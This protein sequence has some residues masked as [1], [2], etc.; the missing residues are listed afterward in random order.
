MKKFYQIFGSTLINKLALLFF[1]NILINSA[2]A[3][4]KT[5]AN[6]SIGGDWNVG[7]N[8][9]PAGVPGAG[10]DVVF[11]PI[12]SSLSITNVQTVSL[13]SFTF[14]PLVTSTLFLSGST[15]TKT[16]TITGH[17]TVTGASQNNTVNASLQISSL[18]NIVQA[19]TSV[20]NLNEG[21]AISG[22]TTTNLNFVA[23]TTLNY[24]RN[25][26]SIPNATYNAASTI[27]V[28][29][30]T[31]TTITSSAGTVGNITW[32]CRDQTVANTFFSGI[33]IINGQ[34]NILN[35]GQ[36]SM[37]FS[38][39]P[40]VTGAFI[41]GSAGV[42]APSGH[43]YNLNGGFTMLPGALLAG[44]AGTFNIGSATA[45][46][47]NLD[48]QA[49]SAITATS[50]NTFVMN[51]TGAQ[52]ATINSNNN[53]NI[54]LTRGASS[55]T[56]LIGSNILLTNLTTTSGTG[57][58]ITSAGQTITVLGAAQIGTSFS[59]T[60]GRMSGD[61]NLVI[62]NS[63]N[64]SIAG[65]GA[66]I[67][68]GGSA[69]G[70]TG[71]VTVHSG[72]ITINGAAAQT[73]GSEFP[74][75]LTVGTVT[76]SNTAGVTVDKTV[77]F[78]NYTLSSG[79]LTINASNIMTVSG[80]TT[81]SPFTAGVIVNNG[82]FVQVAPGTI[83]FNSGAT[84]TGSG[85]FTITSG[86]TLTTA[87]VAGINATGATGSVQTT[88]RN[89]NASANYT[90]NGST[91]N[92]G[93]GMP[94]VVSGV[95]NFSGFGPTLGAS[96]QF[97]S[98]VNVNT[99]LTIT[100]PTTMTIGSTGIFT[101]SSNNINGT[102]SFV[103][104]SGAR[105]IIQTFSTADSL[106]PS[107]GATT[108]M[109]RL[110]G[111]TISSGTIVNYNGSSTGIQTGL[112][113]PATI[114]HLI[115]SSFGSLV[116]NA[117]LTVSGLLFSSSGRV[118]TT[119]T[120]L[121]TVNVSSGNS[122]YR[123]VANTAGGFVD[124]P[125]A[126]QFPAS[127]TGG[128]TFL[129]PLGKTTPS[130]AYEGF[131]LINPITGAG[132]TY[133][134]MMEAFNATPTG[135]T[136]GTGLSGTIG[137]FYWQA[138]PS[139]AGSLTSLDNIRVTH[140]NITSTLRLGQSSTLGGAY[141]SLGGSFLATDGSGAMLMSGIPL[142]SM[143]GGSFFST[144]TGTTTGV[145]TGGTYSVGPTG[146]FFSITAALTAMAEDS[147]LSGPVI[148]ELQPTYSSTVE[149]YPLRFTGAVPTTAANTVTIRPAAAV[150]SVINFNPT[151]I[152]NVTAFPYPVMYPIFDFNGG[153]NFIIDGRPGGNGSNQFITVNNLGNGSALRLIN[154]AQDNKFRY[155]N[156]L[157][158]N[159]STAG[160]TIF[161]SNTNVGAGANNGNS[162]NR[163]DFCDINNQGIN[164]NGIR[165]LGSTAPADNK[166]DTITNCKIYDFYRQADLLTG[167]ITNVGISIQGGNTNWSIGTTV[168]NG[169]KFYQ[170]VNRIPL[171]PTSTSVISSGFTAINI[172]NS[173]G[174]GFNIYGNRIGGN[175]PGITG[176]VMNIGSPT[177]NNLTNNFVYAIRIDN[178]ANPTNPTTLL[179][180]S[181]QGNVISDINVTASNNSGNTFYFLGML[182]QTGWINIG[183]EIGNTIGSTTSA[184]NI[185]LRFR[186]TG[187]STAL[188]TGIVAGNGTGFS[189]HVRNNT[190]A[191]FTT[192]GD[193]SNTTAVSFTGIQFNSTAI[194]QAS[195]CNN[196][197]V[198]S[199]LANSIEHLS[200]SNMPSTQTGISF[201]ASGIT[202]L[203]PAL[204]PVECS[205]NIVQNMT[206]SAPL[207]L[208]ANTTYGINI[209]TVAATNAAFVSNGN[210]IRNLAT[211]STNP[212]LYAANSA[213]LGMIMTGIQGTN[214][215]TIAD[216]KI[217]NLRSTA[218]SPRPL[219]VMG[220]FYNSFPASSLVLERNFIHSLFTNNSNSNASQVGLLVSTSA[221]SSTFRNNMIR[222]GIQPDG[223]ANTASTILYG[224]LKNNTNPLNFYNNSVYIGGSGVASATFP[225]AAFY[226]IAN[227]GF[228]N[229]QNNIFMNARSNASGSARHYAVRYNTTN[230][231]FNSNFNNLVATGT[232]GAI[233]SN[234]LADFNDL[235]EWRCTTQQDANSVGG[236]PQFINPTGDTAALDLHIHAT[237]PSPVEATGTA[238]ASVTQ[239]Y[240]NQSRSGLTP[241]DIGADAGNFVAIDQTPPSITYDLLSNNSCLTTRTV[242]SFAAVTD[243]SGINTTAGTKPR[244]YFKKSTDAN[245]YAGNTSADNGWKFVEAT[246]ATSPFNFDVTYGIINGGS[247]AVNDIIQY[248]VVAQD[249]ATTPNVGINCG[250]FTTA[251]TSVALAAAAF[252]L[253]G[254]I[255]SYTITPA[256][257]LSGVKTIGVGQNFTTITGTGG[258][259]DSINRLGLA[260]DITAN[261][262]DASVTELGTIA[263]N[264]I[265]GGC[266]TF[267]VTI[268]PN[269]TATLTGNLSSNALIRLN[270]ADNVTIDGSNSGGSD[271]S[272]TISNTSTFGSGILLSSL[273]IGSG[274]SYNTIKNC[275]ISTGVAATTTYGIVISGQ[276]MGTIGADN[277]F[278]TIQN[279]IISNA[280][281]GIYANGTV[282]ASAGGLD[283][284]KILNNRIFHNS[285]FTGSTMGLQLGNA[286]NSLVSQD[287]IDLQSASTGMIGMSLE[288]GFV[289]S[290]LDRNYV[291]KCLTTTASSF[292]A[293]GINVGTGNINSNL[294]LSNNII[295]NVNGNVNTNS[296]TSTS[297]GIGLGLIG[298]SNSVTG[299]VTLL[300]NSVSMTGS[301]GTFSSSITHALYLSTSA[302]NINLRNNIFSNT[303][304]ATNP[305]QKNFAVY[306]AGT[307]AAFNIMN[308][309]NYFVFN[310]GNAASAIPGFT[311]PPNAPPSNLPDR[312]DSA[313]F[314][315]GFGQNANSVFGNPLF[316]SASDLRPSFGIQ[317]LAGG[318]AGTGVTIDYLGVTRGSPP[319]MGA[320]ENAVDVAGPTM[321]YSLLGDA[322]CPG[323]RTFTATVTD[324][325]GV[326]STAGTKPRIYFKKAT[327]ANTFAGNTSADNGWKFV[328][329]ASSAS[330]FSFTIDVSLLQ[331]ALVVGDSIYYF[332]VSQDNF[333]TP[334]I[335]INN[336]SFAT[337]PTSVALSAA[338]FPLTGTINKYR[339]AGSIP[340]TVTI[341]AAGTYTSLTGSTGSLFA[342]INA[343]GLS[344]N[345]VATIIDASVTETGAVALNQFPLGCSG[346]GTLTIKPQNTGTIVTGNI[347]GGLIRLNGADNVIIDG[348]TSGG[349]DR[350]LTITN[351]S[352][353]SPTSIL[354]SSLGL[355]L[356]ANRNVIKNCN[357]TNGTATSNSFGISIGGASAGTAGT[358][359]D[360]ITIQNNRISNAAVGIYANGTAATSNGGNDSLQ[361]LNNYIFYNGTIAAYGMRLGNSLNSLISQDTMSIGTSSTTQAY[362]IQLESG[363]NN[364]RLTRNNILRSV[365]TSTGGYG[366]RG[367]TVATGLTTSNIT[368]DNNMIAG[369]NGDNWSSFSNGSALGIG[370]GVLNTSLTTVAGGINIYNNTI[371]LAGPYNN[372]GSG[373]N[374]L[375]AALYVGSNA[376][377]LDI[378]NNIFTNTLHN[379]NVS[380]A[381]SKNY[382]IY[383][384]A[385]ITAFTTMNYNNFY[386][387]NPVIPGQAV[388]AFMGGDRTNLAGIQS[389][390]G[391]NVNSQVIA[392]SFKS[393]T[394]LHVTTPSK[395]NLNGLG[396]P[397]AAVTV[398]FDNDTRNATNPDMGADE[399]DIVTVVVTNQPLATQ[400]VCQNAVPTKLVTIATENDTTKY[401]WFTN[402]T[403]SKVGGTLI[404][405]ATDTGYIPPTTAAGTLYYF[406]VAR[407]CNTDTSN[408]AEVIVN[409]V[410]VIGTEPAT[411]QTVCQNATPTNISVAAA[412]TG[413][414]TYQ[415]YSNTSNSNSG[416]TSIG[417][418]TSASYTPPTS[419]AGT[420]YYYCVVTG[421]CGLDT[422]TTS[423]VIVNPTTII[424]AEPATT[425]T[426]CQN[427]TPTNISVVSDGVSMSYQWY[428]NTSN[429]K[430]GG[431]SIGSAT[432][433]SYTPPTSTAG[434]TYYYCV[435]TGTCGL[436]TSSTSTVTINSTTTASISPSVCYT[437][438]TPSGKTRTAS[439]TFNDTIPNAKG[440]DSVITINLTINTSSTGSFSASACGSYL[441]NGITQTTSGT[442]LDTL[443]NANGCDSFLTLN[444]TINNS[445]TG[446]FAVTACNSYTFNGSAR[447]TSG[448]Y[449][450]TLVNANG[451]DSFLTLNLTI[452]NSSTGS[453]AVSACGSYLFNGITQTTSGA[454]LDT[455]V[456][457]NGCDSF[458]TLNLTINNSSTGSFA[459]SACGS[460]LFNGITQTTSGVY[461]DTLVNAK[462]CDSFL[463]LI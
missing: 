310:A 315:A 172:N 232:G 161:F 269:T 102:G 121:L 451:C 8:W 387:N 327:D 157:S 44:S 293:K 168:S 169:N 2:E 430:S 70:I 129:Y 85:D 343:A 374:C 292:G 380:G 377:N 84:M 366:G 95:V 367:I 332:L 5:W 4:V 298:A 268:K 420:I 414:L 68:S 75:P 135:G 288:S 458:L 392:T 154:D 235:S 182:C 324:I 383:S 222:L 462:G 379:P 112:R 429:S 199:G 277:D 323:N 191:G 101:S 398:D 51:G 280:A 396:T 249:N 93:T 426:V 394:N 334:N 252:P 339:V 10:D 25:G 359:N 116:L 405:G 432:S 49:G 318:V 76:T 213:L 452:N 56:T 312:I 27:N 97:D 99:A 71:T 388:L 382:S 365:F 170:T 363:F 117:P 106:M 303:Q 284:L 302:S 100:S 83:T 347:S 228:D 309:N 185:N 183:N 357:I 164:P 24:A 330:P 450:D 448:A 1:L 239:D 355:G 409:P 237:N 124:G 236:N 143:V 283:S 325:S 307:P 373:Q 437:Y 32:N 360:F 231:S 210:I 422:S 130:T 15:T 442:Y 433:S 142:S 457:A 67:Q 397:L 305:A 291:S 435:V 180:T 90:F 152:P 47:A 43:T 425:Q 415:W 52:N 376:S 57:N 21:G 229:I 150:S 362:G 30:V 286:V 209:G 247:V 226:K 105:M 126:I 38:S 276:S 417:S 413:T 275:N 408:V 234:S 202:N 17:T 270:G 434:T 259:F 122:I 74:S 443:V 271:R 439:A 174:H 137:A 160:A 287:T 145:F 9:L 245:I 461:L 45:P 159:L 381:G 412:G 248:F 378:R 114:G 61:A 144:G 190:V 386:V 176:S 91:Y 351:S 50:A 403:N 243:M 223:T 418:A 304:S 255:N 244:L 444:L 322:A 141:N 459:V 108:G 449:F 123:N 410:T 446:S 220:M 204:P 393:D 278:V 348:S 261:I 390:F 73:L 341:G 178:V 406:C 48:L 391:Q 225:T 436:D 251:P 92:T 119:A 163:I 189:G 427:V 404:V 146:S 188:A 26:G 297:L 333:T 82:T 58:L 346:V 198:G 69:L 364:S 221:T 230:Y 156:F 147:A 103:T 331:S 87:N 3:A 155:M 212:N 353:S 201:T 31:N 86:A 361:I 104:N 440:C 80:N 118:Q 455:L 253:T 407:S 424:T 207:G 350:S 89:F 300:H 306:N 205:N 238:I 385:P 218:A 88:T 46:T 115:I 372:G 177:Q 274:A 132:G 354:I 12:V 37:S 167:N 208:N 340:T 41:V 264:P 250:G 384:V 179:P 267:K 395:C 60:N 368:I 64:L 149:G 158:N 402:T 110:S 281:I 233:G 29:G 317:A 241:T 320:F 371:N 113:F 23:G 389:G 7:A 337:A 36:G 96:H 400:T 242:S 65:T 375:T 53:G 279:N 28:T 447:T 349:T 133:T 166:F 272:L 463:T 240:D 6:P 77:S 296:P 111:L 35:T 136:L 165:A 352:T 171:A 195:S 98:T 78:F 94:A 369:V 22:S 62:G 227:S 345:T 173:L 326:N 260:G 294:T 125:M 428:S 215:I 335:G 314:V 431:T 81:I 319:T 181:I 200:T 153:K 139:G 216:N 16:L 151:P 421:T 79:T 338:N 356:G 438:T 217:Y 184:G 266:A 187:A 344:G 399:F 134:L 120:N 14:N 148:L 257:T 206:N 193:L 197:I 265:N 11:S 401:Q 214:Q 254:M 453:F 140:T 40:T 224:I 445:S 66:A 423:E 39:F 13:N 63:G 321:V 256:G 175:I 454:Y 370:I 301:L 456:N 33:S 411:T 211:A 34:V 311:N 258:F 186:G 336:G 219:S 128:G 313:A 460:Y 290:I 316:Q 282:G 19:G 289:N 295:T 273:G 441:F 18:L 192:T 285:T 262:I 194:N 196:N 263:L 109:F 54:S 59:A 342:A 107:A 131:E 162:G 20:M 416:G 55:T 329:S 328:E 299:G 203:P 358:D 72:N 138:S 42:L 127:Y 308:H 419:T 246:N